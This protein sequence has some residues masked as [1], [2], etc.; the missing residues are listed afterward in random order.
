MQFPESWLRTFVDPKLSTDEL[1]HALTMAGLELESLPPVALVGAELPP[2]EAGGAPFAIKLSKLRGV[3]SQGML[4]SAR[5]LKLS[6]DHSGLMI[7][8]TDTPI[9][10][11]IR[12][13]LN[14]DDTVFEIKL[15]PNKADCLSVFGVARETAAITGAPL[16]ALEMP[17]VEVQS[18]EIWRVKLLTPGLC[19][20]F[21]DHLMR[22]V[23]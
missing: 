8:P 22:A 17:P 14:L 7:L 9:G 3:E 10:R 4:C 16:H 12:Q 21:S 20:R 23:T 19:A 6:E 13:T 2:A 18:D 15:T 5:E 11:D 1:S